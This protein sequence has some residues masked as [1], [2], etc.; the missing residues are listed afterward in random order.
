MP[1]H[2]M[3]HEM[4][5]LINNIIIFFILASKF[6]LINGNPILTIN[7]QNCFNESIKEDLYFG[8]FNVRACP[9]GS[10]KLF[11]RAN[12]AWHN[13]LCLLLK[14]QPSADLKVIS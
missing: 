1:S 2:T 14:W 11:V 5:I 4:S 6:L 8:T 12:P 10:L 3:Y 9:R 13:I 7:Y